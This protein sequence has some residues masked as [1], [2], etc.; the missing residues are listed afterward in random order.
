MSWR[1][2]V[3][4]S[5]IVSIIKIAF[6]YCLIGYDIA[7]KYIYNL[8]YLYQN[9]HKIFHIDT[10]SFK[11]TFDLFFILETIPPLTYNYNNCC[12]SSFTYI[13]KSHICAAL[14]GNS[15]HEDQT[16]LNLAHILYA[17]T[18]HSLEKS[19]SWSIIL[20]SYS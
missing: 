2:I 10:Y 3:I 12:L 1:I 13:H 18:A 8:T 6:S 7:F 5:P 16:T 15:S 17:C 11:Q 14:I 19:S 4:S 9:D 20:I